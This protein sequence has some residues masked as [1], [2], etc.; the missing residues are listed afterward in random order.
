[1]MTYQ[2]TDER[3]SDVVCQCAREGEHKVEEHAN[4]IDGFPTDLLGDYKR[5]IS[6]PS[7]TPAMIHNLRDANTKGPR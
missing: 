4:H 2:S 6:T 5:R 1:M 3:G 7:S